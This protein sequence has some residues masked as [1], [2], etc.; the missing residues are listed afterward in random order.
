[1]DITGLFPYTDFVL[2]LNVN[3]GTPTTFTS[4]LGGSPDIVRLRSGT[5]TVDDLKYPK[6]IYLVSG[7]A[8]DT[9]LLG[10]YPVGAATTLKLKKEKRDFTSGKL[11]ISY[12]YEFIKQ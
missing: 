4:V 1:M 3:A 8:A 7:T 9:I 11:L 6:N 12:S 10:G 2:T 5:W